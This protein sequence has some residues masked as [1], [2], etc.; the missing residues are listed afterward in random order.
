MVLN[1]ANMNNRQSGELSSHV[2]IERIRFN[3]A[4]NNIILVGENECI[5]SY[6]LGS[7]LSCK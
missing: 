4:V 7:L 5:I 6:L 1:E 2:E 3:D